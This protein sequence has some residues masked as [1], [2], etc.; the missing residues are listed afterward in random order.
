VQSCATA[1]R[2]VAVVKC[3]GDFGAAFDAKAASPLTLTVGRVEEAGPSHTDMRD[4][5]PANYS[6]AAAAATLYYQLVKPIWNLNPLI[7][8]WETF[9]E[10]SAN[11]NWQADFYISLMDLAEADGYRLGL[12]SASVGNPP[13]W[14]YPQ[15]ARACQRARQ[16][17]NHILCLH[18][19]GGIWNTDDGR[20][21]TESPLLVTRY[22]QLYSYLEQQAAVIPLVISECG[23]NG[24]GGFTGTDVF[25]D[26]FSWYDDQMM[27]DSFVIGCAAWTLGGWDG[28]NFRTALPALTTYIINKVKV[29]RI[30]LPLIT[31]SS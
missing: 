7:D 24:G 16:S 10:K 17:G 21:K 3:V 23:E 27:R 20:L 13:E 26:D 15:I 22:R 30:Y 5:N 29:N 2:P 19:Y 25:I 4:W 31:N 14:A 6:S 11:W 1:G 8:V 28:A 18:E 9:N 12:W